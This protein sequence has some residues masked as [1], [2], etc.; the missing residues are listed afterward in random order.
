MD[1]GPVPEGTPADVPSPRPDAASEASDVLTTDEPAAPADDETLDPEDSLTATRIE[2]RRLLRPVLFR[3]HFFG[4]FF[5]APIAL[6]LSL[7][8]V[9]F[10]WNPQIESWLFGDET[11]AAAAEGQVQPLSDQVDAALAAYPGRDLVDVTPAEGPGE[12]TGVKLKPTG[13]E[14]EG[15]STAPGEFT[16]YVDPVTGEVT[17]T[18]AESRRPDEWIRNLHSNFRLGDRIGTLTELAGSWVV[19]SL[20]TGLYL[21]WPRT[22]RTWKRA[23]A[24]RLSGLRGGGRLPWRNL[25]SSLGVVTMLLL[26]VIVVTGLTWTEYA[27]RWVDVAKDGIGAE[28]PSLQTELA[29]SGSGAGGGGGHH[30]G[31][32]AEGGD[33]AAPDFSAIDDVAAA[34]GDAQ[35]SHPFTITPAFGPDQAWTVAESDNLWPIERSTVAVDPASGE[36]VDQVEFSQDPLIDQ[37]TTVGIG[38][39]EGTLFGLFNQILLTLLAVGLVVMLVSAYVMWWKRRPAGA[40][41]PPPKL[42]PIFRNVPWPL[43]LGFVLLGV[44]LPT[45]GV[46]FLLFLLIERA[47][48]LTRRLRPSSPAAAA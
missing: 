37:A 20:L 41:G 6:W 35:L 45:L 4:G 15:F 11:A 29:A 40:F 32:G 14:A 39:H 44:L 17:G 28:A 31:G 8:G 24:P 13:A 3:L 18:V 46:S 26:A 2:G 22:R 5:A 34:A 16:A 7:T 30:E 12:T 43:L 25:H 27:G 9:L 19:V 48:W 1:D 10:A 47:V 23:L 42:G 36:V 33:G 38:F 21:W